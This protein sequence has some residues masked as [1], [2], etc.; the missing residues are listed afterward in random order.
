M[1]ED[2]LPSQAN[3]IM[4]NV[5]IEAFVKDYDKYLQRVDSK[6]L[7]LHIQGNRS[8]YVI[9]PVK[10]YNSMIETLYLYSTEANAEALI[11]SLAKAKGLKK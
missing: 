3:D 10:E 9:L 6:N 11:R 7:A 8:T 2:P 1:S 5:K 4:K